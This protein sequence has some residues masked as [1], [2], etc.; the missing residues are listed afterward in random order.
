MS[1]AAR[2]RD[3]PFVAVLLLLRSRRRIGF[4]MVYLLS[5]RQWAVR[6]RVIH[7][8]LIDK[9]DRESRKTRETSEDDCDRAR[10]EVSEPH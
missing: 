9:G 10:R 1:N 4:V 7:P 3:I 6:S 8:V 5:P 2:V